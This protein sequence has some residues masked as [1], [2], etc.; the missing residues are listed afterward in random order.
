MKIKDVVLSSGRTG[1]YFDDQRAIKKGAAHGY[2]CCAAGG[3][4]L[5]T[6]Y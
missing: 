3:L 5:Y 1:F 2:S 4:H 6:I